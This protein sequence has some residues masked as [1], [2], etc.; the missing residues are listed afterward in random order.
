MNDLVQQAGSGGVKGVACFAQ[1]RGCFREVVL[2]GCAVGGTELFGSAGQRLEGR[3]AGKTFMGAA[4]LA[5]GPDWR[6]SETSTARRREDLVALE[7]AAFFFS[8]FCGG[9]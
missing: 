1:E 6:R 5:A 2:F 8:K 4:A 9:G 7:R 3:A